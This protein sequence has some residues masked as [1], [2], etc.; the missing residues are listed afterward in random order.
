MKS[1][2]IKTLFTGAAA[3][4]AIFYLSALSGCKKD[5]PKPKQTEADKVTKTLTSNGGTWTPSSSTAA[6]TIDGT[7]VTQDLFPGFS[8][9]FSENTFTTTG[10]SPV[11]LRKDTWHFKDETAKIII[12]GQDSKEITISEVSE[13]QLKLTLTWDETTYDEGRKKSLAGN[14]E[15]ILNK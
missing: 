2:F 1:R 10:T 12:R 14:Y 9:T 11:W 3:V 13:S 6:I 8:I 15:F 7:D 5:D 4:L